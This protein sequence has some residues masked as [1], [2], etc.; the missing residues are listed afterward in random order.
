MSVQLEHVRAL[1]DERLRSVDEQQQLVRLLARRRAHRRAERA[2]RR[3]HRFASE[4][5]AQAVL[6]RTALW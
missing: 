5:K 6:A 1:Y 4:A 2:A 3:A